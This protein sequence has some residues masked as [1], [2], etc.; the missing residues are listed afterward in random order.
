MGIYDRL[1]VRD[2]CGFGLI[3]H[4][5]GKA[6]HRL[7]RTAIAGLARMAHRGGIAADGKTGDGCGILLQKPDSFFRAVAKEEGW[8]LGAK[9]GVGMIFLNQKSAHAKRA[10]S[11]IVEELVAETLTVVGWRHVP[12]QPDVLGELARTTLPK[13]VQVFISAPSGWGTKD[14]ERRL[15]MVRRR[16]E[17]R[18]Q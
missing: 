5:G 13:I 16:I 14:L 18:L 3:A 4:M 11:I 10:K 6:S 12:I 1:D 2:N 7:V 17:K 15:F 8:M 9:Y